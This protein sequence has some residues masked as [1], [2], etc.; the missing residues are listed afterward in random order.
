M[1]APE[2][3]S[4]EIGIAAGTASLRARRALALAQVLQTTLEPD[5]L[6]DLF[7]AEAAKDLDHD[8]LLYRD[9][10][11]GTERR[12]GR[13]AAHRCTYRLLVGGQRLGEIEISRRRRFSEQ[14]VVVLEHLL[15]GLLYPLRNALMYR[16]AVHNA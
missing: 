6:I 11:G 16:K 13:R 15:G 9:P 1:A 2:S 5:T 14:E 3:I 10:D 12:V 7:G 4:T 8:G